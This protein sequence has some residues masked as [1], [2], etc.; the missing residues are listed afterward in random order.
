MPPSS[1]LDPDKYKRLRAEARAPY[2]GLRL[3]AYGGL[4]ASAAIGGFVFFFRVLAGRD[5]A[6][7]VPNLALQ[8]GAFALMAWLFRFEKRRADRAI[9]RERDGGTNL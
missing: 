1:Q 8:V 9:N 7:D 5:L 3:F 2:R 6:H 4:G